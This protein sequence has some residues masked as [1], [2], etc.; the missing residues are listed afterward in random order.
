MQ[1]SYKMRRRLS[2]L[3][4]LVGL[5]VYVVVAVNVVEMFDRPPILVELLIWVTLGVAWAFP[6]RAVFLGVGRADPEAEQKD[7]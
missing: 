6:L 7:D 3:V 5:P 2:L 1:L 4:L